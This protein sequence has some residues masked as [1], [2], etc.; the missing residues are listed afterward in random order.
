MFDGKEVKIVDLG[1]SNFYGEAIT[2]HTMVGT[3][4]YWSPELILQEEQNDKVD[5]WCVGVILFELLYLQEPF[6]LNE[7][8]RKI[9][10]PALELRSW[11]TPFRRALSPTP[12]SGTSSGRS[13][14]TRIIG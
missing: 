12:T 14:P 2:R 13:S 7:I 3:K 11:N 1:C 6:P 5:V 9:R 8:E 10:V 4:I